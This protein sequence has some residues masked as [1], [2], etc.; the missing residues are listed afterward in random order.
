MLDLVTELRHL[1]GLKGGLAINE[2]VYGNNTHPRP[3]AIN[4]GLSK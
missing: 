1:N 2:T 4:G 3:A